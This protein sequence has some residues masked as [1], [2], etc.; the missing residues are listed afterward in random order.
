MPVTQENYLVG[1]IVETNYYSSR[2]LLLT[3]LNSRIPVTLGSNASQ[4]IL[5]GSGTKNPKLEYLPENYK[6]QS[7]LTIFASGKDGIF[8]P[9][10][11][12][13]KTISSS[14]K[15]FNEVKLFVDPNQLSFVTVQLLRINKENN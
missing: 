14:N 4:A 9:G 10:T 8:I 15:Y 12:I 1:R 11:P 2:V 5:T 3:D 7:E 6:F 13:G